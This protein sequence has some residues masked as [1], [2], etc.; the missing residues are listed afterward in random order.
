MILLQASDEELYQL[1]PDRA[2]QL[3]H[4]PDPH[5]HPDVWSPKAGA[6]CVDLTK[7]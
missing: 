2:G 7:A 6:Q 3:R 5:L 4:H 1:P